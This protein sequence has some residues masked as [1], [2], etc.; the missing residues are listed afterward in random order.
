MLRVLAGG[1][2]ALTVAA[3]PALAG[4]PCAGGR[5]AVARDLSPSLPPGLDLVAL[6]VSGDTITIDACGQATGTLRRGS[7]HTRVRAQ[8]AQCGGVERLHLAVRILGPGCTSLRATARGRR[9]RR[10]RFTATLS[11][12]GDAVLDAG[13]EQ[14]DASAAGGDA[15]CPGACAQCRCPATTTTTSTPPVAPTP[16]GLAATVAARTVDLTWSGAAPRMRLLRRLDAPPASAADPVATV[17][18]DGA[19]TSAADDLT[20]LLP[21]VPESPRSYHYAV[22]GCS[23]GGACEPVGSRTTLAPTLVEALRGGGY[24]LHWRHAAASVCADNLALGT[25][26]TTSSPGWWRSCDA[27]CPAGGPVTATARQ[28]DASGVQQG[29][30]I[31]AELRTRGIPFG[32][33]VTSEYCRCRGTAELM[34]LGPAIE[35]S[36]GLTYFVYDEAGRCG[37]VHALLGEQPAAGSNTAL[38]GHAGFAS[39]CEGVG[40]LA[41]GEAAVYKPDGGGGA[42]LI[43]RVLATGWAGLP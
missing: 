25:A 33:V 15:A 3:G 16:T 38:V 2:L 30:T 20:R 9:L 42:Q 29:T 17:V 12:C 40:A 39:E 22:F 23:S 37:A 21:S 35:E 11:R 27:S 34:N 10:V 43:T 24:V 28:L 18:F 32:R 5:F 6:V 19:A 26:A 31:G 8:W 4:T 41:W 36:Q 13:V 7:R 14:C 1:L